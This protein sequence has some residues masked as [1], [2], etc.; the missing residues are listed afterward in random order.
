MKEPWK[1]MVREFTIDT[2][3]GFRINRR[4]PNGVYIELYCWET[5]ESR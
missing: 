1:G 3:K 5:L 2:A 4:K